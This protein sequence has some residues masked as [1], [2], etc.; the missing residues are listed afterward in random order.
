MPAW[1]VRTALTA[2]RTFMAEP[3]TAGQVG[4]LEAPADVRRRL[5]RDS[6]DW[7]CGMGCEGKS[8]LQVMR[9]WWT[10]CR[11]KGVKVDEEGSGEGTE[12]E[13][14]PEGVNLEARGREEKGKSKEVQQQ[15]STESNPQT[16]SI[17]GDNRAQQG[18]Q[19]SQ[20]TSPQQ[21][22]R[23]ETTQPPQTVS[24]SSNLQPPPPSYT[25]LERSISPIPHAH[26]PTPES[27]QSHA[28]SYLSS[29]ELTTQSRQRRPMMSVHAPPVAAA[30]AAVNNPAPLQTQHQHQQ[31]QEMREAASTLTVDRAIAF[32]FLM[33]V[34]MLLKKVLYPAGITNP[35]G[36]RYVDGNRAGG[37]YMEREM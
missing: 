11:E 22:S 15:A 37:F 20:F 32:V 9:E 31:Q 21:P 19:P 17:P 5:A 6:R 2:L 28:E 27:A 4:G 3:G 36:V 16:P 33:L 34:L 14:L 10:V 35:D 13:V 26:T 18:S 24:T 23:P 12:M 30:S 29:S 8:N 7:R 1:G 25:H